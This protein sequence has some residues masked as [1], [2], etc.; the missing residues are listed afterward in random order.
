MKKCF[1]ILGLFLTSTVSF[2]QTSTPTPS[3]I[4]GLTSLSLRTCT[5]LNVVVYFIDP[6][7]PCTI[8]GITNPISIPLVTTAYYDYSAISSGPG[9]AMDPGPGTSISHYAAQ[10]DVYNCI[11]APGGI[12]PSSCAVDKET[13]GDASCFP[14]GAPCMEYSTFCGPCGPTNLIGLGFMPSGGSPGTYSTLNVG[15]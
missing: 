6:A 5:D 1:I 15:D 11:G 3:T 4:F 9:W 14:A 12:A 7:S 10:V 8:T 13:L 2:A